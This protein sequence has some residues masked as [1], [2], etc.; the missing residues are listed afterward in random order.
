MIAPFLVDL[1]FDDGLYQILIRGALSRDEI[2]SADE[3]ILLAME[4]R[5]V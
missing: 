1:T 3:A 4:E 5:P 2:L